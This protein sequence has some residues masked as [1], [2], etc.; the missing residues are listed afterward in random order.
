MRCPFH[1]DRTASARINL[2]GQ[3]FRCFACD[4]NGDA[5]TVIMWREGVDFVGSIEYVKGIVGI[6]VEDVRGSVTSSRGR[7]GIL[8]ESPKIDQRQRSFLSARSRHRALKG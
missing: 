5:F 4:I 6:E 7:T 8:E 1:E 3:A 2:D